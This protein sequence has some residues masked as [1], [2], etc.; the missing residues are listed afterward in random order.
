MDRHWLGEAMTELSD[1][2]VFGTP[3]PPKEMSDADVFGAPSPPRYGGLADALAP[4][5]VSDQAKP[6]VNSTTTG[7]IMKAFGHG[8]GEGFGADRLGLSSE[9]TKWLSQI[10]IFAPE[11]QK[12][13][14]NPFQA[15]N[16]GV[17]VNTAAFLDGAWRTVQ[18]TY[19]G[20][21]GAGVELGHELSGG[22]LE[23]GLSAIGLGSPE[24]LMRD[25]VSVP[26]AL[27]GSPH[28]TGMFKTP[29]FK[30]LADGIRPATEAD[31]A[32]AWSKDNN[33]RLSTALETMPEETRQ[34]VVDLAGEADD[35]H[36]ATGGEPTPEQ[37][38]R[39]SAIRDEVNDHLT[40]AG[41]EKPTQPE[42]SS[43]IAAAPDLGVIG[44]EKPTV[45]DLSD[46]PAADVPAALRP[47]PDGE[48]QS[49]PDGGWRAR[50]DQYVGKM[51][52][53]EDIRQLI[54]DSADENNDFP[55][56][57]RYDPKLP[58]ND[59]QNLA[60]AAGMDIAEVD[61]SKVGAQLMSPAHVD[62]AMQIMIQAT[63]NVKDAARDVISDAS[64]ENL[65]KFQEHLM[66]R[67]MAVETIVGIRSTWGRVGNVLN[68][69]TKEVKD[70]ASLDT[71]IKETCPI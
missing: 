1:V 34:K 38:A 50:F 11:G 61:R 51:T 41:Y 12:A 63:R 68:R 24:Q 69:Y 46:K 65:I 60:D 53:P 32:A 48:A 52:Q 29:G 6:F 2:E 25:V 54:R 4:P 56:A 10:G 66:R 37:Q 45:A 42:M 31:A 49:L 28:P 36:S 57:R 47:K 30:E 27:M 59:A 16:E 44:P 13:Y 39:L 33:A 17:L 43:P 26:D 22:K 5:L 14:Q 7:G 18:G 21:Q 23:R 3:A 67:D 15:F 35:I 19:R 9:S 8:F 64:E 40:E 70:G 20:V 62:R 58:L 71:F 55:D